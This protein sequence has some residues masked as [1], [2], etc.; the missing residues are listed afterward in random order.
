M[1]RGVLFIPDV[2]APQARSY[3]GVIAE[4]GEGGEWGPP[5][6]GAGP[7]SVLFDAIYDRPFARTLLDAIGRAG[8]CPVGVDP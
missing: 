4:V 1:S 8:G 5:L 7:E 6:S 3:A 2:A